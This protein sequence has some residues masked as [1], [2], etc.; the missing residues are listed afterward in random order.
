MAS[1]KEQVSACCP[2]TTVN[3]FNVPAPPP[4]KPQSILQEADYLIN[5]PRR[6]TYGHP[7]DDYGRT[8]AMFSAWL[9]DKLRE[10]LTAEEAEMFMVIVK[11]SRQRHLPKRDNL[12]DAAGY[13]G[14]IEL[15]QAERQRR[16]TL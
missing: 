11:L 7:L 2:S 16:E 10:P 6:G 13:L 14:C 15:T 5:G 12:V 1:D 4:T 9:G 8:A 3:F